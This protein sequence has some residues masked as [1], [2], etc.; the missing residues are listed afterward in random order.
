MN[1]SDF[2][3]LEEKYNTALAFLTNPDNAHTDFNDLF[4]DFKEH[5]GQF[6]G[7]GVNG[8]VV[9]H[10]RWNY[11]LKIFVVDNC[12][13]RFVRLSYKMNHPAFPVFLDV[14]KRVYP[15]FKRS[16]QQEKMYVVRMEKLYDLD[17]DESEKC[18]EAYEAYRLVK[19]SK[20]NLSIWNDPETVEAMDENIRRTRANVAQKEYEYLQ[21][22]LEKYRMSDPHINNLINGFEIILNNPHFESCYDDIS[23][24]NLMKRPDGQFVIVDPFFDGW[25]ERQEMPVFKRSTDITLTG[26]QRYKPKKN[27]SGNSS[28]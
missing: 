23:A 24:R 4:H 10:P 20:K 7:A 9:T 5:G 15:Q 12:Y 16:P 11:V 2:F 17:D 8:T 14:P 21:K 18:M 19:N 26:G 3:L 1:F 28:L 22:D 27:Q 6:L 13:V 25:D